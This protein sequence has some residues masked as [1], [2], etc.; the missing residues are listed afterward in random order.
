MRARGYRRHVTCAGRWRLPNSRV[1]ELSIRS[2]VRR[3]SG[4]GSTVTV[5]VCISVI[6]QAVASSAVSVGRLQFCIDSRHFAVKL[7]SAWFL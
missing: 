7:N 2:P 5:P 1:A 4:T 3:S 6:R